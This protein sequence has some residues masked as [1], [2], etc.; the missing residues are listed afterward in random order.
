MHDFKKLAVW[1]L[2]MEFS[3][4]ID[5][6]TQ[7][8]PRGHGTLGGQSRRAAESI[9]ATIAEGCGKDTRAETIRFFNMALGSATELESHL[10]KAGKKSYIRPTELRRLLDRTQV[11]QKMIYRLIER[12][13]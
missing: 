1:N 2:A 6:V 10:I 4:E 8:S 5:N 13:P 9:Y 7:R 3:V 12:L 11:I